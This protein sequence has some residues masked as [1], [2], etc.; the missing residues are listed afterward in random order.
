MLDRWIRAQRVGLAAYRLSIPRIPTGTGL[1]KP[2]DDLDAVWQFLNSELQEATEL[3]RS[4]I[5]TLPPIVVHFLLSI[6]RVRLQTLSEQRQR[7][8]SV[9]RRD[10]ER[11]GADELSNTMAARIAGHHIFHGTGSAVLVLRLVKSLF[12]QLWHYVE[13]N[14]H[15]IQSLQQALDVL[16]SPWASTDAKVR[17]IDDVSTV[18]EQAPVPASS[19]WMLPEWR[20]IENVLY[21]RV[22]CWPLLVFEKG[23]GGISFPVAVDIYLDGQSRIIADGTGGIQ[24]SGWE[25]SLQSA[26]D[27][28]KVLW[29][30]KHGNFGSFRTEIELASV[31][32][33]FSFADKIVSE[34]PEIAAV[35]GSSM[36]A[37]FSQI[38]L[39]RF[40]GNP[41]SSSSV[42]T[43]GI[44]ARRLDEP[45]GYADYEFSWPQRVT[46]KIRYVFGSE[47]F[48]RMILPGLA[49][50]AKEDRAELEGL[51]LESKHNQNTELNFVKYLQN[52]ADSFQVGGWRQFRYVRCPDIA[53]RIHPSG[54][55]L[56]QPQSE[57]VQACLRLLQ[58]NQSTVLELPSDWSVVDLASALWH[59]NM[60]LRNGIENERPPM[61]S[62]CFIRVIPEEQDANFW[63]VV[64]KQSGA[65]LERFDAF[66]AATS[67]SA[68]AQI[69]AD[70][71]NVASPNQSC[72][73]HRAPDILV[74]IG[75]KHFRESIARTKNPLIRRLAVLPIVE[76]LSGD[77]FLLPTVLA[78][79]Q[80]WLGRTR[81]IILPEDLET[82]GATDQFRSRLPEEYLSLLDALRVFRFGFTQQMAALL[83]KSL[84]YEDIPFRE[85][86]MVLVKADVLR[87]GLGE[88]HVPGNIGRSELFAQNVNEKAMMHFRAAVTLAPYAHN[89]NVP[90]LA[91]DEVFAPELVHEAQYHLHEAI[92]LVDKNAGTSLHAAARLCMQRVQ[93]FAEYPTWGIVSQF[94][95]GGNSV[96]DAYEM[97]EDL[98]EQFPVDSHHPVELLTAGRAAEQRW[99]EMHR[100]SLHADSD[101]TRALLLRACELLGQ[102][103]SACEHCDFADERG[104]NR[105]FVVT[106]YASFVARNSTV[107]KRMGIPAEDYV[108]LSLEAWKLIGDGVDGSAARGEW[109]E[110]EGDRIDE[111]D[112]AASAYRIGV[113]WAPEWRQL[114]VKYAGCCTAKDTTDLLALLSVDRLNKILRN[115]ERDFRRDWPTWVKKRWAKGIGFL[116]SRRRMLA[117]TG[118]GVSA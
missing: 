23:Q 19:S 35:Q 102:A 22:F 111:D 64:W 20:H 93:R 30:G 44:G 15:C 49:N 41:I 87:Y 101:D 14:E 5:P 21:E 96:K 50:L 52:V 97:A 91:L 94:L 57:G 74:V 65:S 4:F 103:A 70:V 108:K 13:R 61:F 1:S 32:F 10:S 110:S 75:T 48:E 51:L 84:G 67:P 95:K 33:D 18:I 31:V 25:R 60:T 28:A 76:Q 63:H 37:Y 107:L 6:P 109:Y 105:L 16:R 106:Q 77:G 83:W 68:A 115:P 7:W 69:L 2:V 38:V 82:E 92:E 47:S 104:F 45:G 66:H 40:L 118:R 8:Q 71:L 112:Q 116:E 73:S 58:S 98:L 29:R 78:P 3:Y 43:G 56:P 34:F 72:R 88:Y 90:S 12:G 42:V 17:V 46:D 113:R 53:W 9:T 55:R 86:L 117:V 24:T 11:E 54:F 89:E 100:Q 27:A 99:R 79:L 39:S 80:Q 26:V 81:I 85:V 62:W 59:V 114:W 36:E